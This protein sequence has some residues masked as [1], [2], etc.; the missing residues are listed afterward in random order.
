[1]Q[2]GP[3]VPTS[4]WRQW[5]LFAAIFAVV[6]G[7]YALVSWDR[8]KQPSPHFHFVDMA[9]SFLNGRLDTD[10][11][12][13]RLGGPAKPDDPPGY[14]EAIDRA[15]TGPD[16]KAIGWNDWASYRVL[17]LNSGETVAG[18][19]PWKDDK[20]DK[21][22]EF[23]TLTG[24]WM[25]IDPAT[26]IARGCDPTA[27][28]KK[29]DEVRYYISFPPVPSLVMMPLVAIWGY[30]VND[31]LVTILFAALNAVL[32]FGMMRVLS[33]RGHSE[34]Q[35]R[36]H[37]WL[38][39][40]FA[41]GTVAFFSSVR[42][43]VWFTALVIGLTLNTA[44]IL[45]SLDARHPLLAG[46]FL[47]LGFATRTPILFAT[48]F[49]LLQLWWAR[50]EDGER[51]GWAAMARKLAWFSVPGII[52]G[53]AIMWFN[54]ARFG[55]PFEFGHTYL[56]EGARPAIREH[57]LFS[58]WFLNRNL[59]AMLT[60][61][62]VFS[63]EQPFVQVTRHGLGLIATTPAF[64]A[65]LWPR[66][67]KS[68][69]WWSLLIT[70]LCVSVPA[71]LYQ[72]TGWAQFGYRFSL[73]WTPYLIAMLAIDRRHI[74]RGFIALILIGVVVNLFG[75]ATFGRANPFYYD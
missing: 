3:V 26:D 34:R 33:R 24:E 30:H 9:W 23:R 20:G 37:L 49:F 69:L 29:C 14:R 8:V 53:L 10:T 67:P 32:I 41:F 72:N 38:T 50:R 7:V 40:L 73:D 5:A 56:V 43:E 42:G 63:F 6:A 66:G 1:M 47:V 51:I 35:L 57:G 74:G 44:Y 22:R 70:V 46:A 18:V 75:A 60:N 28:H 62:P 21:R 58:F 25:R 27:K 64:L 15:L 39:V 12:R 16:G 54:T 45:A 52:G 36:E 19:W 4:I 59:S 13:Q 55:A 61:M 68:T 71:A 48:P 65:L 17:T 11:P 31:V 2:D